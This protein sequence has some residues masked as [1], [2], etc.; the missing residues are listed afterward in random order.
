MLRNLRLF[1]LK[2]LEISKPLDLNEMTISRKTISRVRN[3]HRQ[4]ISQEAKDDFN[5]KR[6][7]TPAL[8][9]DGK[10]LK[11]FLNIEHEILAILISG[12]PCY[13]EGKVIEIVE[14]IDKNGKPT[15]TGFAQ[16]D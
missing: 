2:S 4:E 3:V 12:A 1:L 6:H 15:S 8:H 11:D 16:G 10:F 9:R 14:L 7:L 13:K 5:L